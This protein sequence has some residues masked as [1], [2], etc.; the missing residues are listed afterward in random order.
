MLVSDTQAHL[1]ITTPAPGG[2]PLAVLGSGVKVPL[3]DGRLV[4]YANLDLAATAPCVRAA[5]DAVREILPYYASVHRGAGL[6]SR[7]CTAAYEDSRATIARFL[8]CRPDD[9]LIFTRGTTDALNLLAHIVPRGTT[10]VCFV[11]EH[12]ANLLPWR[13]SICLPVPA[14]AAE[15]VAAVDLALAAVSGPV[16][17]SMT[18]ASNVT[19]EIWPIAEIT[20]VARRH[21]A[22]IAVDAAQLAP[23]RPVHVADL[24]I[25]Y[26]ALSGHKL[27]APFGVG[28]LAGR[29][30]WLESAVPYLRGGGA[31]A[32]VDASGAVSWQS[33]PARHEAGTPTLIGA[34]SLAAVCAALA[35]ADRCSLER[36]EEHLVS[37]LRHGLS[38][39]AGIHQLALFGAGHPRVGIVSFAIAGLDSAV[40]ATRLS[41]EYGVGVRDGLFCAHPLTRHLLEGTAR[42]DLPPTAVRASLG[43]GTTTAE[44]DRLTCAVAE[45]AAQRRPSN[46]A[47]RSTCRPTGTLLESRL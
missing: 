24:D 46:K 42:G 17:V 25:D 13:R 18:G 22:R 31:S 14:S 11:S 47:A 19:G 12:H 38:R 45:I 26:V 6:L 29:G 43:L 33:G 15:A 35:V 36:G 16:L 7:Y 20:A 40:V 30:D 27:Y 34:V 21:G 41:E 8:G 5:A 28:V 10:V 32:Q 44:I 1:S 2:D 39:I 9:Q 37:R 3:A 4:P 23:H